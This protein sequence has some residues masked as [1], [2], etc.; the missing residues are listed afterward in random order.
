MKTMIALPC[1]DMV[2]TVFLKAILSLERVGE[3]KY[4]LSCSSLVYDARNSLAKNAIDEGFD[5]V[6]WLDSDMDF[7]PDLLKRLSAD[8]D[9][10]RHFVSGLYFKR[11]APISPVIYSEIGYWKNEEDVVP[12]AMPYHDYPRDD[13]FEIK[14][15]GFGACMM[16]T[17]MLKKVTETSGL[18][19]SP[20]VGFGE[21]L[22]FCM[23]A[24]QAGYKMYC[25]SR[26]KLGHVGYGVITEDT[27]L[28]EGDKNA[29]K[30]EAGPQG[31]NNGV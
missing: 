3:V 5:R 12:F 18:P 17:E 14:G 4:S 2:H 29:A 28:T 13:I 6:L 20:A 27:Y 7:Q 19:F 16:S 15:A 21:D 10:G 8:M 22:S 26:I 24:A 9:E 1:M 25:D 30:S 23:R 31:S 11:K